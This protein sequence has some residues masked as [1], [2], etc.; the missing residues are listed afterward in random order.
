MID[1]WVMDD[2][3]DTSDVADFMSDSPNTWSDGSKVQ[4]PIPGKEIAQTGVFSKSWGPA[5]DT[6]AWEHL[7]YLDG[8]GVNG[9]DCSRSFSD[10]P[11]S[12]RTVQRAELW[13]HPRPS[14]LHSRFIGIDIERSTWCQPLPLHKDGV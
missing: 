4:D 11:G 13:G 6:R 9:E 10:R 12:L 8:S 1:D 2:E 7:D 3:L 5:W 14:S